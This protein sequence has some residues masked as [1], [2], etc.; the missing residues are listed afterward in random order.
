M[1]GTISPFCNETLVGRGLL[2][3]KSHANNAVIAV[4]ILAH[5]KLKVMSYDVFMN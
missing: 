3:L 4:C 5:V 2:P 1:T